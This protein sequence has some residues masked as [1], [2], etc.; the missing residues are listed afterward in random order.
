VKP[1]AGS[2]GAFP[3]EVGRHLIVASMLYTYADES[4]VEGDPEWAILAGYMGGPR[5]WS[6]FK[7]RWSEILRRHGVSEFHAVDFYPRR[8]REHVDCYRGWSDPKSSA[9]LAE[10]LGAINSHHI[11]PIACAIHVPGWRALPEPDRQF[12]SGG[13]LHTRVGIDLETNDAVFIPLEF[14][15][16]GAPNRPILGVFQRFVGEAL[17]LAR[18]DATV[19]F[20]FDTANSLDVRTRETFDEQFKRGNLP[21]ELERKVGGITFADSAKEP[22]L[23][24]ADLYAYFWQRQLRQESRPS[25]LHRQTADAVSRKKHHLTT[26]AREHLLGQIEMMKADS[27]WKARAKMAAYSGSHSTSA[28]RRTRRIGTGSLLNGR[29][30]D[31]CRYSGFGSRTFSFGT[32]A[33]FRANRSNRSNSVSVGF[34]GGFGCL[35]TLTPTFPAFTPFVRPS[36]RHR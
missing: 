34:G 2:A 10:L 18:E 7:S 26:I 6:G 33:S 28:R 8:R 23:Q 22:A 30:S 19:H 9:F 36:A 31:E 20:T 1:L 5:Q 32:L 12:L 14:K 25:F 17:L 4:G 13:H 21:D 3:Y 35:S 24:A 15:T 27:V 16:T 11:V 29:P